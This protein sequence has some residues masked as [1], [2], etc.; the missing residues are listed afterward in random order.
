M[1]GMMKRLSIIISA[2]LLTLSLSWG[3][4]RTVVVRT[5]P[6]AAKAEVK[7]ARPGAKAAWVDGHWQ[8]NGKRYVWK[9]G[10]WVKNP[11]GTWVPGHWKKN[12]G[13]HVWVK[14]HWKR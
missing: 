3:C 1:G 8:W 14:G 7:P 11:K 13:G 6:P 12:R 2:M 4:A 10:H 9:T 5:A